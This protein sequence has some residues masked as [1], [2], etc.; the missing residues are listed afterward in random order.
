MP[1]PIAPAIGAG[2]VS[3]HA[4]I[5]STVCISS[6]AFPSMPTFDSE[7]HVFAARGSQLARSSAISRPACPKTSCARNF[8]GLCM[9]TCLPVSPSRLSAN[10]ASRLFLPPDECAS[11]TA[12]HARLS[13]SCTGV[14]E[15]PAEWLAQGAFC[16]SL[17]SRISASGTIVLSRPERS[18]SSEA[19][20]R[21]V[22]T[23]SR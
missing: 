16:Y 5:S 8:R 17:R 4:V 9:K 19:L 23:P 20:P 12:V 18:D 15:I 10:A 2:G 13:D 3:Q 22:D 6:A 11:G 1:R 14:D 21:P 7:S